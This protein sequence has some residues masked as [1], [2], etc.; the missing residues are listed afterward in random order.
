M[1]VN[2]SEYLSS[3]IIA[4]PDLSGGQGGQSQLANRVTG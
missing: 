3:T 4:R 2:C 1:S